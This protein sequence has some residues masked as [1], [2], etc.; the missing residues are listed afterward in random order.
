MC[1]A[2]FN[3]PNVKRLLTDSFAGKGGT[4][5]FIEFIAFVG[6]VGLSS[7]S[8]LSRSEFIGFVAFAP[9][10][11]DLGD[12]RSAQYLAMCAS[13]GTDLLFT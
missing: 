4:E 2:Y 9:S 10:K 8:R 12:Q 13:F 11:S 5:G 6:F 7:Y 1:S 3:Y